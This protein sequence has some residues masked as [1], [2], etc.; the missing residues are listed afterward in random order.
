M[1]KN[2]KL[3]ESGKFFTGNYNSDIFAYN[4]TCNLLNCLLYR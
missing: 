4:Y 1:N 3:F 2:Q